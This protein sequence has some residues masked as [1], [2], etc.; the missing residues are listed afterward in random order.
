M[1]TIKAMTI[2]GIPTKAKMSID[3]PA[4]TSMTGKKIINKGVVVVIIH[5]TKQGSQRGAQ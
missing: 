3:T 4:N 1:K 2:I 5:I